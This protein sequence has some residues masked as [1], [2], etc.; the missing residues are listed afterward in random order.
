LHVIVAKARPVVRGALAAALVVAAI[1]GVS[2]ASA[3]G[4]E[5]V[6]GRLWTETANHPCAGPADATVAMGSGTSYSA[7][8]IT[9][10]SGCA[11]REVVV[12]VVDGTTVQGTGSW[13]VAASGATTVP[14]GSYTAASNLTV[15]AVVDG[16]GL[17]TTWSFT[18]PATGPVTCAVTGVVVWYN[19]PGGAWTRRVDPATGQTCTARLVSASTPSQYNPYSDFTVEVTTTGPG[20][21]Q[22]ELTVDFADPHFGFSPRGIDSWANFHVTSTCGDRP[23]VTIAGDEPYHDTVASSR[24]IS[25]RAYTGAGGGVLSCP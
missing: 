17:P 10:P 9:I 25:G 24:T 8:S 4:L 2:R 3:A 16:W 20:D 1:V 23:L 21:V 19:G 15:Q 18:P 12:T 22:W 13:T 5:V 14:V 7:V 11:G 6:G